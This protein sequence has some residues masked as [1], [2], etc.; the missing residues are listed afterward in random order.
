MENLLGVE[1]ASSAISSARPF[2]EPRQQAP[3]PP[4]GLGLPE[5]HSGLLGL[6]T[7]GVAFTLQDIDP[8]AQAIGASLGLIGACREPVDLRCQSVALCLES[9][10]LAGVGLAEAV[11]HGLGPSDRLDSVHTLLADGK[12]RPQRLD[13]LAQRVGAS[14]FGVPPRLCLGPT[15]LGPPPRRPRSSA[16]LTSICKPSAR[17]PNRSALPALGS[18]RASTI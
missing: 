3:R 18:A 10:D 15:R 8:G 11:D 13:P 16:L 1:R 2:P 7:C 12:L 17:S 14:T 6:S 5:F 9:T 4:L